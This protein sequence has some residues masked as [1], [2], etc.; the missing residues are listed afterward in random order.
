MSAKMQLERA[1][2]AASGSVSVCVGDWHGKH[3]RRPQVRFA[4]ERPVRRGCHG[5]GFELRCHFLRFK[6][7]YETLTWRLLTAQISQS[8]NVVTG[9]IATAPCST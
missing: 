7:G 8:G 4:E 2:C 3:L 6:L 1:T 5:Q 9:R